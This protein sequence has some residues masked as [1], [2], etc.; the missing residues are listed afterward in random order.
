MMA[1]RCERGSL[2]SQMWCDQDER[3]FDNW[4][5]RFHEA[6]LDMTA[7]EERTEALVDELEQRLTL[8]GAS[9]GSEL[10]PSQYGVVSDG[11][12]GCCC[13]CSAA[14]EDKLQEGVPETISLFHKAGIKVRRDLF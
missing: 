9:G 5:A 1:L 12:G 3:Y 6:E 4:Q 11:H 7:K 10:K 13:G 8:L 2:S 14:V